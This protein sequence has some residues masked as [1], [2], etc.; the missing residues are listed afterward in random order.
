[1]PRRVLALSGEME[2]TVSEALALL[3]VINLQ[4]LHCFGS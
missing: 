1:M 4:V 2:I 3:R